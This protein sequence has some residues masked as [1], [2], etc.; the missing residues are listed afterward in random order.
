MALSLSIKIVM[1]DL[2]K[3]I[4]FIVPFFV[5]ENVMEEWTCLKHLMM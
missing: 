2:A 3:S 1:A 4:K 5:V